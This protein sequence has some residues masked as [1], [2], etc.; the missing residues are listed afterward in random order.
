M[1]EKTDEYLDMIHKEWGNIIWLYKQFEDK[2]PIMLFDAQ[3]QKIYA[4]PNNEF[5]NNLSKK[6]Q[7]L[8]E[9]QY[10]EA[11]VNDYF[12]IFVRDSKKEIFRSYSFS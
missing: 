6:S 2:K 10:E 8:L 3:E 12:V 11:I 1:S 5:K 7:E 9:T 4:Y